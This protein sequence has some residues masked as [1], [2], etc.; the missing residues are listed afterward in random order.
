M[1]MPLFFM[2]S[3]LLASRSLGLGWRLAL[4][5]R[6]ASPYLLYLLWFAINGVFVAVF[7]FAKPEALELT[8]AGVARNVVMPHTTLWYMMAL[9]LFFIGAKLLQPLGPTVPLVGALLVSSV[10]HSTGLAEPSGTGMWPSILGYFPFFLV[11]ALLPAFPQRIANLSGPVPLVAGFSTYV[12][13]WAAHQVG[14]SVIPGFGPAAALTGAAVGIMAAVRLA[15][16]RP[17]ARRF[18]SIGQ[19]TLPIFV[20]HVPFLA[21]L[22]WVATNPAE[23]LWS[24]LLGSATAAVVYPAVVI[25][26]AIAASLGAHTALQRAGLG[27][28]FAPP[29]G[30][31]TP[32]A[33]PSPR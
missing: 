24:R 6:A 30:R 3:G 5:R 4:A 9:P 20:L 27:W 12:G 19:R 31:R 32:E 2:L 23:G 25:A 28:L 14:A 22:H 29:I 33:M 21:A 11:G 10:V 7:D 13:F 18:E 8:A 16:F 1:R 26:A 15:R 17:V